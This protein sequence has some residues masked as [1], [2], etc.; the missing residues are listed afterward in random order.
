VRR[1][2]GGRL[3]SSGSRYKGSCEQ[4]NELHGSTESLELGDWRL[5]NRGSA[6]RSYTPNPCYAELTD[7][8]DEYRKSWL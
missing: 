8:Q 1:G 4:G 6:P 5:L 2:G 7:N 3:G